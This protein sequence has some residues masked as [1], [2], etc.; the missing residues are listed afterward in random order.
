[1]N[2]HIICILLF[3][4]VSV[5]GMSQNT[6][7][8][9]GSFDIGPVGNAT[10]NIPVDLPSGTAGVKPDV[11]IV[12]NSF[13]GDGVMGKGF[14]LSAISS[15]T[16]VNSTVFHSGYISDI[17]FDDTDKY[18]LDGNRLIYDGMT[19]QYRTEINPYSQI[20]IF[21]PNTSSAHFEVRTK[22]GLIM[23]YGNTTDSRL[24]AQSPH[25]DQVAFWMLSKVRDRVGNYY[26]YTYEFH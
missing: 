2:K 1:M 12:Y 3:W 10:Y 23:E 22:D 6:S 8:I 24:C 7:N 13:S 18:M 15:I 4:V 25:T 19:Q 17:E 21:S 11:S 9:S 20:K 26:T 5:C 14:S 16:R